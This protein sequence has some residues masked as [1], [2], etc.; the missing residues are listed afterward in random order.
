MYVNYDVKIDFEIPSITLLNT[1]RDA[2]AAD[3]EIEVGNDEG[4]YDNLVEMIDVLAK[5]CVADGAMTN[6]QWD[7]LLMRY[8]QS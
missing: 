3:R 8:P 2:E 7:K 4:L 6:K 1:M 5:L